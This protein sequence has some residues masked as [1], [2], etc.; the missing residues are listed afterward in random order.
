M[1]AGTVKPCTIDA[2][3]AMYMKYDVFTIFHAELNPGST[4]KWCADAIE[5]NMM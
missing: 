3:T 4:N 5:M 2:N 1:P